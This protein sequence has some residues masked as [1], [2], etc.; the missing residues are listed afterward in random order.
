MEN[1]WFS[2]NI[3]KAMAIIGFNME[4]RVRKIEFKRRKS[5]APCHPK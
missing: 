5:E 4:F 1:E 3:S 2:Q